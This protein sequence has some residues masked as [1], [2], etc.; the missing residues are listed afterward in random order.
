VSG[1]TTLEPAAEPSRPAA[2]ASA[3]RRAPLL[4]A[5]AVAAVVVIGLVAYALFGTAEPRVAGITYVFP[6]AVITTV[7]PAGE[8]C[9]AA[10]VP[11]GTGAVELLSPTPSKAVSVRLR[12]RA[13]G[14]VAAATRSAAV[15]PGVGGATLVTLDKTLRRDE[16]ADVCVRTSGGPLPL[17]GDLSNNGMS[18][19]GRPVKGS[20]CLTFYREG[21]ETAFDMIPVVAA[22]IGRLRGVFGGSW[23]AAVSAVLLLGA[24]VLA[25][26]LLVKGGGSKRRRVLVALYAVGTLNALAWSLF[27]PALQIPDEPAHLAYVQDLV[28]KGQPPQ[29]IGSS[30]SPELNVVVDSVNV[31]HVNFRRD[32]RPPWFASDDAVAA[33]RLATKPSR[34][35]L[36]WY[37]PVADYPPAYYAAMAPVYRAVTAEGGSTLDAITPMRAVSALLAGFAVLGVFLFLLELFPERR[38]LALAIAL[39]CA[40][41]PLFTFISGGVNPD[42]LLIPIGVAMFWLF[43]RAFRRGLN[44]RLAI[45]LGLLLSGALLTKVAALGFV[46]GWLAGVALLLWRERARGRRGTLAHG[47]AAVLPAALPLLAYGALNAGPWHRPVLPTGLTGG[48][49]EA[50]PVVAQAPAHQV[51]SFAVYLYEY[52]FPRFG[53]MTD[54]FH[55]S[56]TPK[57]LWVPA[58]LGKFG[59]A[60]YGFS[61]GVNRGALIVY[62]VIALAAI[63]GLVRLVRERRGQWAPIAVAALLGIGLIVAI[64]K[65]GYPLRAAGNYIFEQGRYY[66]PLLPLFALAIALAAR[67]LR[68][69]AGHAI[70]VLLVLVSIAHLGGALALT[71]KRY[72]TFSSY[73]EQENAVAAQR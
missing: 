20:L 66:M 22:R 21:K 14:G 69:R 52:L 64:A 7:K 17:Y 32:A 38:Y 15:R 33:A 26:T 8:V 47:A 25:A 72:Y 49:G 5:L 71:V 39:I 13:A 3:R 50:A 37:L 54:F 48:G 55:S 63:V 61:N 10:R 68:P 35:N 9:Q 46:P 59:W 6:Q 30:L 41:Q 58:W 45:G 29:P 60:D 12:P 16:E 4:A 44:V 34:K 42:A 43:A 65:A 23:R 56:W 24:L 36:A 70:V 57:D 18:I 19:D 31:T 28:E 73:I 27:T 2:R 62:A 51:S 1:Q 53:Q 11:A 67:N 40:Y